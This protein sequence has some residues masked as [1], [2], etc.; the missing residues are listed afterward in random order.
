M[1]RFAL[2]RMHKI[3]RT[4]A[5]LNEWESRYGTTYGVDAALGSS[6]E[7][8][9]RIARLKDELRGLGALYRW[10]GTSY[11]LIET[12]AEGEGHQLADR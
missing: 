9:A 4:L 2:E 5:E 12:V 1:D 8:P 3:R 7:A 11:V 10:D 6:G